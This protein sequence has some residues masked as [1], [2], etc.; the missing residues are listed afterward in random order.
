MFRFAAWLWVAAGVAGF[1]ASLAGVSLLICFAGLLV[2]ALTPVFYSLLLYKH[3]ER[4]G[5]LPGMVSLS[6]PK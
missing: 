6:A 1:V 3:L 2:A 4:A 5:Q